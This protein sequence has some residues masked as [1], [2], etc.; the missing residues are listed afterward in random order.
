MDN[1]KLALFDLDGT[2]FDTREVNYL[3]YKEALQPYHIILDEAYFKTRCN[4]RHY[5]EFIPQIMGST[6]YLE[7]VHKAKKVAYA[8]NLSAA[9]MNKH[10]FSIIRQLEAEYDCVI[11]TTAS[12]KNV[13]DI[14]SFFQVENLFECIITQEDISQPKPDPEGFLLAMKRFKASPQDT[15]IFEDS[16]VGIAAARATGATV[17]VVDQF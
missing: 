16:D 6:E 3:A 1:K 17:I 7:E 5:T 14:L 12:R 2:L 8:R 13:M 9:K 4:G 10:L 11:V 15:M